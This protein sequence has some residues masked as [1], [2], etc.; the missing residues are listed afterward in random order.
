MCPEYG[1]TVALFPTDAQTL[2]YLELTG[3]PRPLIQLVEAYM[4]AQGLFRTDASP[5]PVFSDV[6]SLDLASVQPS[7][8]GPRR[9]QDRVPL[10]QAKAAWQAALP[11][12]LEKKPK[13]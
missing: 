10:K 1:A 7:L 13:G 6:I 3:R 2:A 12:F 9:P 5:E 8:A 11:A 4:K